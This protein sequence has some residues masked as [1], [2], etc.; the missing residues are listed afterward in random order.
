MFCTYMVYQADN[1]VHPKRDTTIEPEEEEEEEEDDDDDDEGDLSKYNLDDE[2]L[3]FF[4]VAYA[5]NTV[6]LSIYPPNHENVHIKTR[7]GTMSPTICERVRNSL[8]PHRV[9]YEQGL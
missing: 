4:R 8:M 7:P 1:R 9:V 5:A 3:I 6:S 2:V